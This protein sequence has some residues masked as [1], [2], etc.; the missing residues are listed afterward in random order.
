MSCPPTSPPTASDSS[1]PPSLNPSN[2]SVS[3]PS[4]CPPTVGG[5]LLY[6]APPW[7]TLSLCGGAGMCTWIPVHPIDVLKVR[8]QL[9][10]EGSSHAPLPSSSSHVAPATG[11]SSLPQGRL[12]AL[13]VIKQIGKNE[14]WVSGFY[15]GLSAG[16]VRQATYTSLRTG[17]YLIMN[18]FMQSR[19]MSMYSTNTTHSSSLSSSVGS[20]G[21]YPSA[22]NSAQLLV[23]ALCGLTSG[24]VASILCC[25]VEVS[26][27]RMQA[28]GRLPPHLRR[29]YHH[30]VNAIYRITKEEGL[31]TCWRGCYPTVVRA[32]VVNTVQLASYDQLKSLI[33]H[34]CHLEGIA[35]HFLASWGAGFLYCA[36]SLP[37]DIAKTRMQNQMTALQGGETG[38]GMR[39]AAIQ[40]DKLKEGNTTTSRS[41]TTSTTSGVRGSPYC[42]TSGS[43]SSSRLR[44]NS[45]IQTMTLISR[46]EGIR[47]LWRGFLP[48]FCRGGTHTVLMFVLLEQMKSRVYN[49]GYRY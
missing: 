41:S 4:S 44:Y 10:N 45:I 27:V 5:R 8:M 36:S 24:A 1:D 23:R 28:D 47:A 29:N 32:M 19:L 13:S 16:L 34:K 21:V 40:G 15:G 46:E 14:G 20:S 30:V 9:L 25:P 6:P 31:A 39:L 11:G 12:G 3:P 18:D 35:G 38:G 17:L 22:S 42:S 26:L 48:Y 49:I 33:K 37:F 2:L 7:L 43:G